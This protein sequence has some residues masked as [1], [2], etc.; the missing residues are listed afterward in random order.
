MHKILSADF[1]IDLWPNDMVLV[2][3]IFFLHDDHFY[4]I[5]FKSQMTKLRF[6]HEQDSLNVV[7]VVVV[8]F[9]MSTVNI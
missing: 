2:H 1:D 3:D 5:I 4:Q 8:S 6:S 9:F 7:V